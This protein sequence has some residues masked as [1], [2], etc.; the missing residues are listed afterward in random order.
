MTTNACV[1]VRFQPSLNTRTSPMATTN[2]SA[3]IERHYRAPPASTPSH[4]PRYSP[5]SRVII[6][7]LA[8]FKGDK[9]SR[10]L[11]PNSSLLPDRLGIK[12]IARKKEENPCIQSNNLNITRPS[13]GPKRPYPPVRPPPASPRQPRRPIRSASHPCFKP[14]RHLNGNAAAVAPETPTCA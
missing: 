5:S 10:T 11:V 13:I 1:R 2:L 6:T 9:S 3:H 4:L 7:V 8:R 14:C 12:W